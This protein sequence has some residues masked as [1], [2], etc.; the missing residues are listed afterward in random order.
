MSNRYVVSLIAS[1][2]LAGCTSTRQIAI[3]YPSSQNNNDPQSVQ[4][5]QLHQFQSLPGFEVIDG[6]DYYVRLISEFNFKGDNV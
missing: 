4:S 5:T 2:M 6:D 1:C 3:D